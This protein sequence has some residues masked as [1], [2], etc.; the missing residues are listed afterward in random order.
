MG[1]ERGSTLLD[2]RSNAVSYKAV[3]NRS[4]HN[5]DGSM[6]KVNLVVYFVFFFAPLLHPTPTK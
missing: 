3:F 4:Y 6:R 2:E 1:Y 5:T